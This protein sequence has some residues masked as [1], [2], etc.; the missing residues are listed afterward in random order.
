[1]GNESSVEKLEI[2]SHMLS[3]SNE[4]KMAF[5]CIDL[6]GLTEAELSYVC[7]LSEES[8]NS[9]LLESRKTLSLK[10][11]SS[12]KSDKAV[13]VLKNI[14]SYT[15][16]SLSETE[17]SN[18]KSLLEN[19][20][21]KAIFESYCDNK[22]KMQNAFVNIEIN[23]SEKDEIRKQLLDNNQ[24][25]SVEKEE[26]RNLRK[27]E[28]N[29]LIFLT[30]IAVVFICVIV[31]LVFNSNKLSSSNKL[32]I[33]KSL[34]YESID[35][36]KKSEDS[37]LDFPSNN[38]KEIRSYFSLHKLDRFKVNFDDYNLQGLSLKGASVLNYNSRKIALLYYSDRMNSG[39]VFLYFLRGKLSDLPSSTNNK[40]RDITYRT[41]GSDNINLIAWQLDSNTLAV[42]TGWMAIKDLAVKVFEKPII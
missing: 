4:E 8:L 21:N 3:L 27:K 37:M 25:M 34:S 33:L 13:N 17:Y 2:D 38:S 29:R 6:L 41:Y 15:N 19:E 1:M 18:Y 35:I 14:I 30:S 24:L 11:D 32:D 42:A 7:S 28:K 31:V 39:G 16:N 10:N 20:D 26:I 23:Q 9:S 5:C 22:G 40:Y 36:I 12:F